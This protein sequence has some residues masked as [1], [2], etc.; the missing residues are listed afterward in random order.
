MT[1]TA[2]RNL[3]LD[4][5]DKQWGRGTGTPKGSP[6]TCYA[7]DHGMRNESVAALNA[8]SNGKQLTQLFASSQ[9]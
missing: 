9:Q 4:R 5:G 3:P 6:V 1:Y 8:F 7:T 2:H